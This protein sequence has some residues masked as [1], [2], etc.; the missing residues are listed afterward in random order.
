MPPLGALQSVD[1]EQS[2]FMSDPTIEQM[3]KDIGSIVWDMKKRLER[4]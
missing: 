2:S 3:I 1:Y 4:G